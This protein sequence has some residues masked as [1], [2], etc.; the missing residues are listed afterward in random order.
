MCIISK[1]ELTVILS[2]KEKGEKEGYE[3]VLRNFDLSEEN[4]QR[5]S[6]LI[7]EKDD[8]IK[9]L[10]RLEKLRTYITPEEA[11]KYFINM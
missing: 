4:K 1:P 6:V 7:K 3:S 10:E 8:K 5:A 9:K 2:Q 11:L